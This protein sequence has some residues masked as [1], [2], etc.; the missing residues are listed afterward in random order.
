MVK[1][2]KV[3]ILHYIDHWTDFI[4]FHSTRPYVDLVNILLTCGDEVKEAITRSVQAQ[5]AQSWGILCNILSLCTS[6]IQ[7]DS[8]VGSIDSPARKQGELVKGDT[9]KSSR[10]HSD[11]SSQFD[12]EK[13]AK[14]TKSEKVNKLQPNIRGKTSFNKMVFSATESSDKPVG[15]TDVRRWNCLIPSFFHSLSL[16]S[17]TYL[18]LW[19]FQGIYNTRGQCFACSSFSDSAA[20]PEATKKME[21]TFGIW[22]SF[23]S[24]HL[25]ALTAF[26]RIICTNNKRDQT[27]QVV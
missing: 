24:F 4:F 11:S 13:D 1:Y 27:D 22:P 12:M 9:G 8:S 18:Q 20:L 6:G 19:T 2:A 16:S 3:I 26:N 25:Q 17:L 21:Q 5:C 23:S 7:G 14:A 15:L 10:S